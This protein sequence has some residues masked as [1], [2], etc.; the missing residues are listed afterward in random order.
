MAMAWEAVLP[1]MNKAVTERQKK[2]RIKQT[3]YECLYQTAEGT[4]LGDTIKPRLN[5]A[6]EQIIQNIGD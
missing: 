6:P 2:K 3:T 1:L 5:T 4:G